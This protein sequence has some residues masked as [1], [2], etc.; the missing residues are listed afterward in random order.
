MKPVIVSD[1]GALISLAL[2]LNLP[3]L[4]EETAGRK[5]AHSLGVEVSGIAR[6]IVIAYQQNIID[7]FEAKDKLS[8]M[9]KANR[10]NRKIFDTLL[11]FVSVA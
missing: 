9:L 8:Q 4:I 6:Q 7:G 3:L 5:I 10:I 11:A 1:T 2:E